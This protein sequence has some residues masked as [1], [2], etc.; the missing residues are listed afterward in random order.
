M[1]GGVGRVQVHNCPSW[2]QNCPLWGQRT[3]AKARD[4]RF[5]RAL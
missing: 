1:P 3:R 5:G 2:G 4:Y